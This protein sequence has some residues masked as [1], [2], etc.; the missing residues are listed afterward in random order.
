MSTLIVFLP[1]RDPAAPSQEW[2]LPDMPFLL[3]D[4]RGRKERAG[5]GSLAFLPRAAATVLIVPAR[6]VLMLAAT[7]P[8]LK[9]PRLRQAL[10]NVV[11]DQ[12]IQDAQTCHIALDPQPLADGSRVLAV[13]DRGWFRFVVEAF[14]AAGHRNLRAV[15]VT[16]CLPAGAQE[17]PEAVESPVEALA[18]AAEA[19]AEALG[20]STD[21]STGQSSNAGRGG[22]ADQATTGAPVAVPP[23]VALLGAV[24]DA[25]ET[26]PGEAGTVLVTSEPRVE[27]AIARGLLGEGFA[28]P[29]PMLGPT[30]S[31]LAGGSPFPL[32]ELT[33]VPAG[34]PGI[35]PAASPYGA[36]VGAAADVRALAFET[37]AHAALDCRFDL[38][39]F[40]FE[41]RPW[42]LDRATLR[43]L[44]VPIALVVASLVVAVVGANIQW[45][46]LARERDALN[47]QMTELLLNA[48]PKTAVVL[49]PP[50]QM[51]T[52][53]ERLRLAA[54]QLSPDDYLSLAARLASSFG[55]LPVNGVAA[56]DY[57]DRRLELTFKPQV[58]ADPD[59]TKRLAQNGLTG[60]LDTNSGKWVVRN[61]SGQ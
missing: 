12:L 40:E 13:V 37:L 24:V 60:E 48:F 27:V 46:M 50:A 30:L 35:E 45:L 4:K 49:D 3:L 34:E 42:R 5:R 10:P 11:E 17:Q 58:T 54:G 21:E 26:I 38:C 29:V 39:Q 57:H 25:S 51:R 9:G 18:A 22:G 19:Q 56:L 6:D 41:S 20:E 52:Q 1:P 31:A 44:R 8:P 33:D 43:R 59:F 61:R 36:Y 23:V 15:P 55:P 53:L 16:R 14:V 32:Y 47:A 7:L 2:Q 28:V